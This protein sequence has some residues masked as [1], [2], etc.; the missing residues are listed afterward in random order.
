M[1]TLRQNN[2]G[3]IESQFLR[4]LFLLIGFDD[5]SS[6]PRERYTGARPSV[7]SASLARDQW[8]G[9]VTR[10]NGSGDKTEYADSVALRKPDTAF[11]LFSRAQITTLATN[12]APLGAK[13]VTTGGG[14]GDP[15]HSWGV[16]A[17]PWGT[18]GYMNTNTPTSAATVDPVPTGKWVNV[19]VR[20][21]SGLPLSI[22]TYYDGGAVANPRV[23]SANVSGNLNYTADPLLFMY[24]QTTNYNAGDMSYFA[25]WN[26]RL[27]DAEL[28]RLA[29]DPAVL[30]NRTLLT[31][32]R[33]FPA[34]QALAGDVL[35]ADNDPTTGAIQTLDAALPV[36]RSGTLTIIRDGV[37]D[38]IPIAAGG[39][40]SEPVNSTD[41]HD[42]EYI[43]F[44]LDPG[45]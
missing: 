21:A 42:P 12:G 10:Y 2:R 22:E 41:P 7:H 25:V 44:E 29:H 11:T 33:V 6:R 40:H 9:I 3:P 14:G 8:G 27:T 45:S 23:S 28:L 20:W 18:V 5:G 24:D 31:V 30:F 26:R 32:M 17:Y 1:L 34:Q 37:P 15:G 19:F 38:D 4:G 36:G 39:S 43:R 16:E 13:R 35:T